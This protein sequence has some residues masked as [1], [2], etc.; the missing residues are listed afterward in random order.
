MNVM[1]TDR[2]TRMIELTADF[3]VSA[4]KPPSSARTSDLGIL[5]IPSGDERIGNEAAMRQHSA[6]NTLLDSGFR[7][8]L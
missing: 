2:G 7:A 5:V 3:C 4:A 1:S 6:R 8:C